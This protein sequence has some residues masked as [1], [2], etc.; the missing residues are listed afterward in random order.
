MAYNIVEEQRLVDLSWR[1]L[2]L[3][4][5]IQNVVASLN[6]DCKLDLKAIALRACNAEYNSKRFAACIM[7][8]RQ[9][10]TTA[11]IFASGKMFSRILQKMGF[12]VQFKDFKIQNIVGS[13][14]V[15][16][17]I[18]LERLCHFHDGFSFICDNSMDF[19]KIIFHWFIIVDMYEP[20]LFPDLI[21]PMVQPKLVILIFASG[22][23]VISG[24]KRREE[25]YAAFDN[26]YPVL[27][28]YR[29]GEKV[30]SL[31]P[32]QFKSGMIFGL[33]LPYH[34]LTL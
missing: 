34:L 14:D 21:Y 28:E 8:I 13:C 10:K 26:I 19:G 23:I 16:F 31:N 5:T 18:K 29:R 1:P 20:E 27:A 17:P 22:K 33:F 6:L 25:T 9:S 15:K 2:G 30:T 24:A 4:P 11:L 3:E 7:R 32:I 12:P